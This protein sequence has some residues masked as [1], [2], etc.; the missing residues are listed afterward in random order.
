[1][2]IGIFGGT[3]NPVHTGHLRVAEEVREAFHFETIY[4]VPTHI[5]PHKDATLTE[6]AEERLK[7]LR[8]ATRENSFFRVSGLEIDRGGVSYTLDTL[9]KFRLRSDEIFFIIGIDAFLEIDTWYNYEEL[10][11]HAGFIIMTRP[12][13]ERRDIATVLPDRLR[14]KFTKLEDN[15]YQHESGKTIRFYGVTILDISSTRIRNL[16]KEGRS[17]RY[18]VPPSVEKIIMKKGLYRF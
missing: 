16:L 14:V 6:P 4:F 2:A 13:H 1:M 8:A 9:K 17:I 12:T 7:M 15:V 11:E 5:P 10:F 18:L 3:F